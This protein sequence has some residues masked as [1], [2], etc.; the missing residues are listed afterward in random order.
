MQEEEAYSMGKRRGEKKR[1]LRRFL[2]LFLLLILLFPKELPT[3]LLTGMAEEGAATVP[4]VLASASNVSPSIL[5]TSLYVSDPIVQYTEGFQFTIQPGVARVYKENNQ[6]YAEWVMRLHY[7]KPAGMTNLYIENIHNY[8]TT[9]LE[10]GLGQAE[11]VG[12]KK[13]GLSIALPQTTSAGNG[14]LMHSLQVVFDPRPD[15]GTVNMDFTVRAPIEEFRDAYL[16]DFYTAVDFRVPAFSLIRDSSAPNGTR[17]LTHEEVIQKKA[18]R[19]ESIA[20]NQILNH[21]F[22]ERKIEKYNTV[23]KRTVYENDT[24]VAGEYSSEEKIRWLLS[25]PNKQEEEATFPIHLDPDS[26]QEVESVKIYTYLPDEDYAYSLSSTELS[27][28]NLSSLTIPSSGIAQVEVITKVKEDKQEHRFNGATLES[29]KADLTVYKKWQSGSSKSESRFQLSGGLHDALDE[30]VTIPATDNKVVKANLPKFDSYDKNGR[31]LSY[32]VEELNNSEAELLYQTYDE[33]S[34][35]FTFYNKSRSVENPM[36]QASDY[37]VTGIKPIEIHEFYRNSGN[38]GHD[39]GIEGKFKIPAKAKEGSYFTLELPKEL[40]LA[41]APD[42]NTP[43][44]PIKAKGGATIGQAFHIDN[45]TLKF[46]LNENAYSTADYEGDFL[47]GSKMNL[48]A[49]GVVRIDGRNKNGTDNSKSYYQGVDADSR[50]FYDASNASSEDVTK[51]LD[52]KANYVDRSGKLKNGEKTLSQSGHITFKDAEIKKYG[53]IYKS[54]REVNSEYVLYELLLNVGQWNQQYINTEFVDQLTDTISLYSGN[55]AAS[56]EKDIKIYK[57][58]GL[59]KELAY[60]AGAKEEIWPNNVTSIHANVR[61]NQWSGN[62]SRKSYIQS[63]LASQGIPTNMDKISFQFTGA[64]NKDTILVELKAKLAPNWQTK[65]GGKFQNLLFTT[66]ETKFGAGYYDLMGLD[67]GIT[68]GLARGDVQVEKGKFDIW[69]VDEKGNPIKNNP[70][71]FVL[72]KNGQK[73]GILFSDD[74]GLIHLSG[75]EEYASGSGHSYGI[76]T[77]EEIEAPSGYV[78]GNIKYEIYYLDGDVWFKGTDPGGAVV[79]PQFKAR[80]KGE[81]QQK[82]TIVNK[83][84][85][86]VQIR[87][88]DENGQDLNGARFILKKIDNSYSFTTSETGSNVFHFYNLT[89]GDYSLRELV[90]PDGYL[91]YDKEIRFRVGNDGTIQRLSDE[92]SGYTSAFKEESNEFLITVRNRKKKTGEFSVNKISDSGSPVAGATFRLSPIAPTVGT[93]VE[94]KSLVGTGKLYFKDLAAGN[95]LLEEKEAPAGFFKTKQKWIVEVTTDGGVKVKKEDSGEAVPVRD[96]GDGDFNFDIVNIKKNYS[97]ELPLTGGS[98][99]GFFQR[100]G[101]IIL[102]FAVLLHLFSSEGIMGKI[103]KKSKIRKKEYRGE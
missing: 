40:L 10:G 50:Y 51:I 42:P 16:M 91:L 87:K 44:F 79:V 35:S 66:E 59:P 65:H 61:F 37:G 26:S 21:D 29:L 17:L 5:G 58:Q 18:F 55:S 72:K 76:Y 32:S 38:Y 101:G 71:S 88:T 28:A 77:L 48:N 94:K 70:A 1:I 24:A 25:V 60:K 63:A 45:Q 4:P 56:L 12:L 33:E 86:S 9:T 7:V 3:G 49:E 90:S 6:F 73:T 52:F 31:R 34:L 14:T 69:K 95:Y 57:V 36:G 67:S 81:A 23:Y 83:K 30:I 39:G 100:V 47:I 53:G 102:F 68:G 46:V 97:Y 13:N 103:K 20:E 85:P 15:S 89:A 80:K 62:A 82:V 11:L 93:V 27:D 74:D 19:R 64:H 98:G 8:F 75:L 84:L 54:V 2:A 78:L 99:I 92:D 96:M 43:Y 22:Q 41:H